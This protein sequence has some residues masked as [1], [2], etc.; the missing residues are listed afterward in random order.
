M[1][2]I[3]R[4]RLVPMLILA[5]G[6]AALTA[7]GTSTREDHSRPVATLSR[8]N[9]W[10]IDISTA[11]VDGGSAGYISFINGGGARQMHP[12][13]G[14]DV[15]P[16]SVQIY[17]FPYI[18]VDSAVTKRAVQFQYADE[19]DGVNHTTGAERSVLPDP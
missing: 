14:G 13:F 3:A 17:G 5:G 11:P 6:L 18:V 8:D 15:S 4:V 9:W 1:R 10:N 2:Q 16:G 19:S 7:S 12:D